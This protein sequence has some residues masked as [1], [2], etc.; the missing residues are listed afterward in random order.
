MGHTSRYIATSSNVATKTILAVFCDFGKF[1][2]II[3][4]KAGIYWSVNK[5]DSDLYQSVIPAR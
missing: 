2:K 3:L 5:G 1:F 4:T